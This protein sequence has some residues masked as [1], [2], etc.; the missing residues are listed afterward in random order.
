MSML[1]VSSQVVMK[2]NKICGSELEPSTISVA[3]REKVEQWVE[4]SQR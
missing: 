1:D 3:Y 4:T 2:N